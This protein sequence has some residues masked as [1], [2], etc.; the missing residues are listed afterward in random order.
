MRRADER[1]GRQRLLLVACRQDAGAEETRR[2]PGSTGRR[3]EAGADVE[4]LMEE[5]P[6]HIVEQPLLAAEQMDAAGHV[7]KQPV[8]A[9]QRHQRG[10]AVAPVGQAFEQPHVGLRVG[11]DDIDA[12][13]HG[14]GVGYAHAGLQLQPLSLRVE[15]RYA[16]AVP[17]AVADDERRMRLRA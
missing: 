9:V 3:G 16:L 2:R 5:A 6:Q 13:M 14:A 7:E 1:Q 4:A 15:G 17:V 8:A 10:V 11:L 12:G